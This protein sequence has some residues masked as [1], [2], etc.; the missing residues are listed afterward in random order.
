MVFAGKTIGHVGAEGEWLTTAEVLS[1]CRNV[2][3]HLH[4]L[5]GTADKEAAT[6]LLQ[7]AALRAIEVVMHEHVIPGPLAEEAA[8]WFS[9]RLDDPH[10]DVWDLLNH[11]PQSTDEHTHQDAVL[12]NLLVWVT[13]PGC[14]QTKRHCPALST[15]HSL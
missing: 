2:A 13:A 15:H 10:A 1:R 14:T 5:D 11:T 6:S 12:C 8:A 9:R 3:E 7:S 4:A